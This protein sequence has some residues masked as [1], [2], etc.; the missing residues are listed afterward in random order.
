MERRERREGGREKQ[1]ETQRERGYAETC[2]AG[3]GEY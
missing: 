1:R 3:R 2:M